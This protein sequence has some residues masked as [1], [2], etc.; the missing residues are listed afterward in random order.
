MSVKP[1]ACPVE[2]PVGKSLWTDQDY[3][4]FI[5]KTNKSWGKR[6]LKQRLVYEMFFLSCSNQNTENWFTDF[7]F[8]VRVIVHA[9]YL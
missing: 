9:S 8:P 4:V 7:F 2:R 6:E 5:F 1:A 3:R